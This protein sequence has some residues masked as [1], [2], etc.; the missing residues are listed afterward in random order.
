MSKFDD[1]SGANLRFSL[2]RGSNPWAGGGVTSCQLSCEF[3]E[4]EKIICPRALMCLEDR[5]GRVVG[6]EL[7]GALHSALP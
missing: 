1:L 3:Y 2:V 5:V 4:I 6:G 7:K